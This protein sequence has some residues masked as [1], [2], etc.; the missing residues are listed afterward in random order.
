MFDGY[1]SEKGPFLM[2]IKS[3]IKNE[4]KKIFIDEEEIYVMKLQF[5]NDDINHPDGYSEDNFWFDTD[6]SSIKDDELGELLKLALAGG[7]DLFGIGA[8]LIDSSYF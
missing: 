7:Q 2:Y 8:T 4:G 5:G 6:F 3:K 1:N